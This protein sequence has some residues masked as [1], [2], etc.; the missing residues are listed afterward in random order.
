MRLKMKKSKISFLVILLF[1]SLILLGSVLNTK[2]F[3]SDISDRARTGDVSADSTENQLDKDVENYL[4]NT[5][6]HEGDLYVLFGEDNYNTNSYIMDKNVDGNVFIFGRDVK[7]EGKINGSLFVFASNVTI[8]ESAYIGVD[9]FAFAE[10][11]KMSGYAYDM[12]VAGGTFNMTEEAIIYRDL[13]LYA[14]TANLFGNVGRNID[15]SISKANVFQDEN[16]RLHVEGNINYISENQ[17]QNIDKT[18]KGAVNFTRYEKA[19]EDDNYYTI[20]NYIF[21][22]I[23]NSIF[24]LV[25]YG[26]FIFLAPK[27][28]E[29]SKEYISARSLLAA[30]IGF[31]F[32]V[33]VPILAFLLICT[34]MGIPMAFMFLMIYGALLMINSTVV[35]IAVNEFIA[36]KVPAL[37]STWKK[38]LMIIPISFGIFIIRK[39]FFVGGLITAIVLFVGVGIIVLYQ[40]D[41]RKNNDV[42][43]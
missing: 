26:L 34:T 1:I 22:A 4:D 7:I 43:L 29:R 37:N 16:N 27:F 35:A 13:K 15:M 12:Y 10:N 21:D 41:K 8:D 31:C 17:I 33:L 5:K 18:V 20:S 32:T 39:V 25:I 6:V 30:L 11:I 24:A 36:N 40:V 42:T 14:D 9:V 19:S 2:V 23:E 38:I 3:G 28:V